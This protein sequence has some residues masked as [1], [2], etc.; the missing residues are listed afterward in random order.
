M[1]TAT[2]S[3]E[4]ETRTMLQTHLCR[5]PQSMELSSENG[6][7]FDALSFGYRWIIPRVFLWS[8]NLNRSSVP[9]RDNNIVVSLCGGIF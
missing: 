7:T 2:V 4:E 3:I 8:L 9:L 6:L 5:T 1:Q